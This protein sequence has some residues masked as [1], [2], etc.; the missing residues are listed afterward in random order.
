MAMTYTNRAAAAACGL[1]LPTSIWDLPIEL[2]GS[3]R[4]GETTIRGS[5]TY[6]AVGTPRLAWDFS[7]KGTGL[8]ITSP[9]ASSIIALTDG[10][11]LKPQ[12]GP[13]QIAPPER[14]LTVRGTD[15]SPGASVVKIGNLSGRIAGDGTWS[16]RVPVAG[17]GQTT[18]DVRDNVKATAEEHIT[19]VDLVITSPAEGAVLPIT[20]APAM[21]RLGAVATIQGYPGNVSPVVFNWALS[22]RGEY[23][24]RC[25]HNPDAFCG[26]WYPYNDVVAAGTTTGAAPWQGDFTR[27][28]GGFGRISAS[29]VVP[30][31]L[32]EPVQSEPRWVDIPGTNPP[33]AT[34]Q[35]FVSKQDPPNAS[36]E[37]EIFCHESGFV[38]F[39]PGPEP[40]ESA[41]T[42]VPHD[43]AQ[44]PAPLRPLFGAEYA[45]IGIAQK[46][47][48]SFPAGQWDWHAN[49]DSGITVYDENLAG[50]R[51]WR[52][53][54][55]V[56]LSAQLA[57]VLQVVNGLRAHR[58]MKMIR[59]VP[60]RVPQLNKA[61]LQ[62][63]AIRRYNGENEYHFNLQYVVSSN[64]LMVR[65]VGTGKWADS[66][67]EWQSFA[68]W[69]AAGGPLVARQ[70]LPAADPGYVTLVKACH[71]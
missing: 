32:D 17:A 6:P 38:Q 31:V 57:A 43:I 35:A 56:R 52:Q 62:R 13:D 47:P 34:I 54:E 7:L 20:S 24:D 5:T 45:G 39:N 41:T 21:P 69:Q 18:L 10:H 30:G 22:T 26:Q 44:N 16:I 42:T 55:Q 36:V 46:D 70:W 2:Q 71:L 11:Y 60:R 12:P 33:V 66:A 37:D 67:G 61:Q 3:Y 40:R 28:E 25:G 50:A 58:G 19:L 9:A 49:V 15:S 59:A 27:I 4:P 65:T 29:A 63:E 1:Q 14:E 68:D 48:S 51:L 8:D 64:H 53:A 23:R